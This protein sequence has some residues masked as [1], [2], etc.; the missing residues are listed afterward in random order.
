MVSA[1]QMP[2][3]RDDLV[4]YC[5]SS[6][7][8]T[9]I[10]NHALAGGETDLPM[11][12]RGYPTLDAMLDAYQ[13]RLT[14]LAGV[15][16][17]YHVSAEMVAVADAARA[18]MPGYR[19]HPEDLPAERGLLVADVPFGRFDP[20]GDPEQMS[21]LD[22]HYVAQRARTGRELVQVACVGALW[23]PAFDRHGRPGVLVVTWSDASR[24]AEFRE[25]EGAPVEE[26]RLL[27]SLGA[28]SY[29]DETVLPF[30]EHYD[31]TRPD[32]PVANAMLATLMCMWLL[33][34]QPIVATEEQPLP[35][36]T[37]RRLERAGSPVPKVRVVR[38]RQARRPGPEQ[39]DAGRTY[40]NRRW[41]VR[42]H[43]RD[44]W[45]P[46]L[47]RHRPIYIPAHIKGPDGAPLIITEKVHDW[48]R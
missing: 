35:R 19:L 17:L 39:A 45:F 37:R 34:N 7:V 24:L 6:L 27:R 42:G 15:A 12:E 41:I 23:G 46:S 10:A 8:G 40:T 31:P 32:Q 9:I 11:P 28:L 3:V 36:Q 29:H 13:R 26:I 38:L 1:I 44:Q 22:Q 33:M 20:D 47:E 4:G 5:S 25:H 43:W 30:G 18:T 21:R 2:Q 48:R 16:E 14:T